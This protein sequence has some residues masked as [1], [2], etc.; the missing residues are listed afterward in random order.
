MKSTWIAV[1]GILLLAVQ[2]SAEEAP[3]L[4]TQQDKVSYG[5]GVSMGKNLKRQG[6]KVN[7]DLVVKG[8]KDALSGG[9]LLMSDGELRTTMLEFHKGMQGKMAK[10]DTAA[11]GQQERRCSLFGEEPEGNRR[12]DAQRRTP[13]QDT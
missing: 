12:G 9:K 8:L 7:A 2:V 3:V 6:I 5:I 13:I 10:V 11:A 1:L 4:K